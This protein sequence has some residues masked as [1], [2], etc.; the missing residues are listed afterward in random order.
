[1]RIAIVSP[2]TLPA[3]SGNSILAERL[4]RELS[5][6]GHVAA[7]F[8]SNSAC[9]GEAEKH[10]PEVVHSLHAVKPGKWLEIFFA[11]C[12]APWIITLTG[13]DYNA[14]AHSRE[15]F[16]ELQ[17]NLD[18]ASALVV[19]H[20][21]AYDILQGA[22][23]HVRSRMHIIPQGVE[24]CSHAAG[25]DSI[26]SRYGLK[27]ADVVFLM[28]AGIR[29]VKNI[30]F[31]LDAFFE[32]E[33]RAPSV[34]LVLAGPVIDEDEARKMFATGKKL[35]CFTCLGEKPHKEVRELMSAADVFLNTSF[36]E[37]MPGAVLEAMAEGLP[38]IATE[39]SGNSALIKD[40]ENGYLVAPAAREELI[41]AAL[42]LAAHREMRISMGA[43]GRERAAQYTV[44]KEIDAYE[45]LYAML[46]AAASHS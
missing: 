15:S 35:P 43:C 1:M 9:C 4:T 25:P 23:P 33:K 39:T 5:A 10:G 24:L 16:A 42:K 17:K 26:R 8:N 28:A 13:T 18:R 31:A 3:H 44:K 12:R 22:F 27:Q 40:G 7:L 38:V 37:G 30:S 32:I 11:A 21:E 29:P 36:H 45:R 19:F 41:A 14:W 6:R 20:N 2:S 34:K 46:S